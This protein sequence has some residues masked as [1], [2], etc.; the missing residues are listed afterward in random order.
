MPSKGPGH[1][2]TKKHHKLNEA[3]YNRHKGKVKLTLADL[4]VQKGL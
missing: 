3:N 1:R 2:K 4:R